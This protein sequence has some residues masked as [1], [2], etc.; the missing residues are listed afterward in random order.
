LR[1]KRLQEV[2][3][4]V[5]FKGADGIGVVRGNEDD[6]AAGTN[7][8]EDLEAIKLGHLNIEEDQVGLRFRDD[9]DGLE[10]VGTLSDKLDVRVR[11]K[12]FADDLTRQFFVVDDHRADSCILPGVHVARPS[13]SAGSVMATEK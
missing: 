7:Q 5:D 9:F 2:V 1:T 11:S 13:L 4:G 3:H 8:L 12:Q 10:T 6:G